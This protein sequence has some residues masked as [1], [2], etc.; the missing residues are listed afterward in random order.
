LRNE[1]KLFHHV[2]TYKLAP[3]SGEL[4]EMKGRGNDKPAPKYHPYT[5]MLS[6]KRTEPAPNLRCRVAIVNEF[7]ADPGGARRPMLDAGTSRR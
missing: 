4:G 5:D 3:G 1:S 6:V 7:H 2:E